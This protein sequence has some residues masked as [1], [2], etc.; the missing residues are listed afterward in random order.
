M[1]KEKVKAVID[2]SFWININK[3]NLARYLLDYFSL[4][5]T[6][7][8]RE[9]LLDHKKKELYTSKDAELFQS[10]MDAELIISKNPQEI[11]LKFKQN[12]SND[13]GEIYTIALAKEISAVVLADDKSAINFCRNQ[14]ILVITSPYF[15]VWLCESGKISPEICY[16][17]IIQLKEKVNK[18]HINSA[19]ADLEKVKINGRI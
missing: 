3:V 9:E 5:S 4:Y 8:V 12:L 15:L 1:V 16:L 10:L 7:K 11:S 17:K 19:L 18:T 14:K 2:S 6:D 13:S